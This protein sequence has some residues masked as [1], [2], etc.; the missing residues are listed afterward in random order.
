MTCVRRAISTAPPRP[1]QV[2]LE[3]SQAQQA[4]RPA[5]LLWKR[6]TAFAYQR[7][8]DNLQIQ[9]RSAEAAAQ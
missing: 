8:G 4:Q 7:L 3:F 1:I 2:W 9:G 6:G 5:S